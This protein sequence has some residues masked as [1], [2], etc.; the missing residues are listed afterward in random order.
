MMMVFAVSESVKLS[1]SFLI[2]LVG[3]AVVFAALIVIMYMVRL[4]TVLSKIIGDGKPPVVSEQPPVP[5]SAGP[6]LMPAAGSSG[7]IVLKDVDEKT[8]ALIMA[9]VADELRAPL[10]ELRFKSIRMK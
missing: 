1:E 7:E 2:S 9:I 5:A 10:N 3:F 4:I 6:R 8:A